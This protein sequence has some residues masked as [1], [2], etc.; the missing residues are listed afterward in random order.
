MIG[1]IFD[2][3]IDGELDNWQLR[4]ASCQAVPYV[5]AV[6]MLTIDAGRL[7]RGS[8]R[9]YQQTLLELVPVWML[10]YES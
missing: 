10:G 1:G 2:A 5:N 8:Q 4:A 7:R 9:Q 3:A 6:W